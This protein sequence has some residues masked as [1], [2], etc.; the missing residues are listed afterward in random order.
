V[1]ARAFSKR[2]KELVKN[3]SDTELGYILGVTSY[4]ARKLRSGEI[5][6]LKLEAALRLARKLEVSPW[7]IAGEREPSTGTLRTRGRS[8]SPAVDAGNPGNPEDAQ[9]QAAEG[10]LLLHDE[11]VELRARVRRLEAAV[12]ELQSRAGV[13]SEL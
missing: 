11:V 7:Y 8:A 9:L 10:T 6:S 2:F 12:S 4:A 13:L 1:A 5:K 3:L